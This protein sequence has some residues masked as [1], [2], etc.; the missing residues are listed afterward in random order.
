[1]KNKFSIIFMGTPDFAVPSLQALHQ[2]GYHLKQ[3]VTQPDRPK[4]RG[5]KLVA[6][7]VKQKALELNLNLLQP[8]KPNTAEFAEKLRQIQPDLL[9]VIAYGH[10][11][12]ENILQIP[13]IGA[14]NVHASLLPKYRGPA[15]IQWAII[16]GETQTGVTTMFMDAGM[17]TGDMLISRPEPVWPTDT[18]ASLH[19]RLAV[20]GADT[21]LQTLQQLA[22]QKLQPSRQDHD[23]ATYA[24]LLKKQDGRIDWQKTAEELE[25]F[26]RGMTPW[27]GAFTFH[28]QNR[29][30][31]LKAAP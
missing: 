6:S 13:K 23:S 24:P 29:L 14:I 15:P 12:S 9:I 25:P 19:D 3:V 26:I 17:D 1:M 20:L 8:V 22:D 16:N 31:I 27:P 30:K 4:G 5:R 11:L 21:L 10:L 18:A 28:N 7:P 2:E